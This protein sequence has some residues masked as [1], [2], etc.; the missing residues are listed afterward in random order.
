MELRPMREG[1]WIKYNSTVKRHGTFEHIF[2]GAHSVSGALCPN[3]HKP[4]LRFF[5]LVIADPNLQLDDDWGTHLHLFFCWTCNVSQ[6]AFFYAQ[7]SETTIAILECGLGGME[8]DFPYENYPTA[9]PAANAWLVKIEQTEQALLQDLNRETTGIWQVPETMSYIARPNHQYA[10]EPFL[11]QRNIDVSQVCPQCC[12]EMTLLISVAD[13]NL[14][15]RG[16]TG[17]SF[18]QVLFFVCES[19]RVVGAIQQCD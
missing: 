11:V 1:Y 7:E 19:C 13:D 5:S 8:Q 6:Q 18:V 12:H 14:D 10:G 3:C 17:N 2:C 15:V 9:F 4:L 16:F